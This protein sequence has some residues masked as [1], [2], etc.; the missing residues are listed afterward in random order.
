MNANASD[1]KSIRAAEKAGRLIDL[2]DQGVIVGIMTNI[3]GR[4][5]V[6]RQ[7]ASIFHTPFTADPHSTAFNCGIQN[8][9]IALLDTVTRWCPEQFILMMRE[10]NGR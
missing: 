5:W 3:D 9:A 10:A 6:W 1:R 2:Q 7:L 4:A 8:A